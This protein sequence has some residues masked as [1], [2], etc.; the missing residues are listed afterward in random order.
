MSHIAILQAWPGFMNVE[1]AAVK[2]SRKHK[3]V[4]KPQ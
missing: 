1:T 4:E 3:L 2:E